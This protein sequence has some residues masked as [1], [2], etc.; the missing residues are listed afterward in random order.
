M[1]VAEII[2]WAIDEYGER[3]L[4]TP[5]QGLKYLNAVQKM[6][7]DKD[8]DAFI[9]F[10]SFLTVNPLSPQGPYPMPSVPGVRKFI[11]TTALSLEQLVS[12]RQGGQ[13]TVRD[14]GLPTSTVDERNIYEPINI[15]NYPPPTTFSFIADAATIDQDADTYRLVYYMQPPTIR[16]ISDDTNLWVPENFHYNLCVEGIKKLADASNIGSKASKESMTMFLDPFWESMIQAQD[17]GNRDNL[18]GEGQPGL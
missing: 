12:V 10:D 5:E 1:T 15:S 2:D 16:T 14:Y 7:F 17:L 18:F 11:G 13:L 8:L 4:T 6:A 9:S 3:N